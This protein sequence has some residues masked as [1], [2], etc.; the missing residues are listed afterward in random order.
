MFIPPRFAVLAEEFL[1]PAPR[2]AGAARRERAGSA[3]GRGLAASGGSPGPPGSEIFEV[4]HLEDVL[5]TG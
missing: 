5:I 2:R 4:Q 1:L 3:Q